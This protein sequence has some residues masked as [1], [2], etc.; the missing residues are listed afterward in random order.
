MT[1]KSLSMDVKVGESVSIDGGRT[2]L[3]VLEKSG[4]RARLRFEIDP[5]VTVRKITPVK[6]GAEVASR[7]LQMA[8]G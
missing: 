3:T 8:P 7:G 4:Q 1:K 5:E 2:L 6:T